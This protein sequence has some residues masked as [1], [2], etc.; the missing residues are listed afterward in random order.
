MMEMTDKDAI[1][2]VF[3]KNTETKL[4]KKIEDY[5]NLAE[6]IKQPFVYQNSICNCSSG[7]NLKELR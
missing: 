6:S 7:S 1:K 5:R 4:P 2:I 3:F